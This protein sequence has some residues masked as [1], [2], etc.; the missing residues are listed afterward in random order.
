MR[1]R[2]SVPFFHTL[3][4]CAAAFRSQSFGQTFVDR[5]TCNLNSLHLQFCSEKPDILLCCVAQERRRL[6]CWEVMEPPQGGASG[7]PTGRHPGFSL[8]HCAICPPL[9]TA[10]MDQRNKGT[11]LGTK[12]IFK[13]G[14]DPGLFRKLKKK[15]KNHHLG[16]KL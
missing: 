12:A 16:L 9:A 13:P 15:K 8:A 4:W 11:T 1:C 14:P 10:A 7:I 5:K 2:E 6:C 3:W